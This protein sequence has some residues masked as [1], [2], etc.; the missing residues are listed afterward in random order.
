MDIKMGALSVLVEPITREERKIGSIIVPN[1]VNERQLSGVVVKVGPGTLD[2]PMEVKSGDKVEYLAGKF[3]ISSGGKIYH[4]L[5]MSE[6][7]F[8]L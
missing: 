6:I 3:E 2:I 4:L 1:T 8:I 7:L 5:R